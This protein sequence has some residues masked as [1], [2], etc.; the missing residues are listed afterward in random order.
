MAGVTAMAARRGPLPQP[1]RGIWPG[2]HAVPHAPVQGAVARAVVR[3]AVRALPL[4]LRFPDGS[5]WGAGGPTLTLTR[6]DEFFRRLGRDGLIGLGEAW[7]TG[8][9]TAG[10][11]RP[12]PP[13]S[14]GPGELDA[15]VL[16]CATD[17]LAAALT[18]LAGRLTE[19]VP[20]P[21]QALRRL[22]QRRQPDSE[23]N[24][25]AGARTNIHRHYDL[26]NDMFATFLDETMTY[27]SAWFEPAPDPASAPSFDA[28][29]PAQ[30]RKID[31]ILDL[32]RVRSGTRLVEIGTGWGALAIRAAAERGATVTSLTLSQEQRDLA[33][34]RIAEAGLTEKIEV[35]LEDYRVHAAAHRQAYDAAASVEMIE[36]VGRQYWPDYFS[37]VQAM[38]RPGGRF[39]LQAITVD[40]AQLLATSGSYT[41]IHKYVFPGGELTS[42]T[43]IE[44]ALAAHT[45]MRVQ[46]SR[47]LGDSYAVT[48]RLWRHRFDAAAARV[49]EL[50][51]DETFRRMWTFYL[52]YS[53]AGFASGYL[54]DYQLGIA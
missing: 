12:S 25:V 18:V 8:D 50:G 43:G 37:S 6:P 54:D 48:L 49:A 40:H 28:L 46:E 17:E 45:R 30:L 36:A 2:L 10:S 19:L 31:G 42:L 29:R 51:F 52:A 33:L 26:S 15:A 14:S 7:M 13:G 39:G 24:S 11:W 44:A 9:L 3:R 47:R 27:S 35:R 16:D 4:T 38:L 22:W 20:R 23:R 1:G 21:L 41:W 32:A 5:T 53:E 34:R